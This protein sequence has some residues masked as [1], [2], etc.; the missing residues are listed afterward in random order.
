MSELIELEEEWPEDALSW[1]QD[2][3]EARLGDF[4]DFDNEE[5]VL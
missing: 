1:L 3:L 4:L 2:D 5:I